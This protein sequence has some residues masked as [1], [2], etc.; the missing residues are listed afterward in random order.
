ME[1]MII[2]LLSIMA[3]LPS[4]IKIYYEHK[5]SNKWYITQKYLEECEKIRYIEN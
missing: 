5:H 1:V 3:I 2:I 4:S